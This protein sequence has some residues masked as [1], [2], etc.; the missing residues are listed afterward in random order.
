MSL[1]A[2]VDQAFER[3]AGA[4]PGTVLSDGGDAFSVVPVSV[5]GSAE[6]FYLATDGTNRAIAFLK[7][8]E[9]RARAF[10]ISSVI[11]VSVMQMRL[12]SEGED[13]SGSHFLKLECELPTL[14][15]AF[16]RFLEDIRVRI[17]DGASADGAVAEAARDW[18][19]LLEMAKRPKTVPELAAIFGELKMLQMLAEVHGPQAA[20]WW[21]GS[22]RERHDF[23]S[24]A[25]RIEVKTT[26][27]VGGDRVTVHGLG[28]LDPAGHAVCHLALVEVEVAP[29]GDSVDSLVQR[30]LAVGIPEQQLTEALEASDY[31][32]GNA[33]HSTTRFAVRQ[34]RWWPITED[35]PGLKASR[36]DGELLL[37]V[38]D[39]TFQMSLAALGSPLTDDEGQAALRAFGEEAR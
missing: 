30:L 7:V 11:D 28:Q 4:G 9:S 8:A 5:E 24:D 14:D 25:A 18:R 29:E 13:S 23:R 21:K 6:A 27:Q 37:G 20:A 32:V 16:R 17:V 36:I 22:D 1:A 33:E 15:L 2:N 39:V 38:S 35:S 12:S 10:R 34:I 3:S 26:T 19:R 31:V